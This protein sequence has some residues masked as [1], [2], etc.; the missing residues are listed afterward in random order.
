MIG[1]TNVSHPRVEAAVIGLVV[2]ASTSMTALAD[3]LRGLVASVN[4]TDKV[5]VVT[6]FETRTEEKIK[7]G[8]EAV[9]TMAGAKIGLGDPKADD[10]R[11]VTVRCEVGVATN[12][13]ID[14]M[15]GAPVKDG[16]IEMDFGRRPESG[17]EVYLDKIRVLRPRLQ[18]P[19]DRDA[20]QARPR[21]GHGDLL[22]NMGPR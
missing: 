19:R 20:V 11:S 13:A 7:L 12:V 10:H 9:I 1:M 8:A 14:P 15:P 6:R 5:I 18:G 21:E 17:F 2:L 22:R 4:I 16:T 3:E